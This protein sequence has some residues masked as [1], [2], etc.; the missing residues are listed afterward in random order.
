MPCMKA[1][2]PSTKSSQELSEN[3]KYSYD[4]WGHMN[5][6][7]SVV[8]TQCVVHPDDYIVWL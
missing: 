1:I 5:T 6:V 2:R 4:P 3:T 8:T 7:F